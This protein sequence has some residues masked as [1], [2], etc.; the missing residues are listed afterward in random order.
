MAINQVYVGRILSISD[1]ENA[2]FIQHAI[3]VCGEGGKW[4]GIIR[5]GEFVVDD[6]CEVYLQDSLL[7][8]IERYAFLEKNKYRIKMMRMRG[9]PSEVLIMPLSIGEKEIGEDITEELNVE[10]YEKQIPAVLSGLAKGNFPSFIPKTDEPN[11]QIVSKMIEELNGK[12][13]YTTV[14]ADGSSTTCYNKDGEFGVCSR[15]LEMKESGKN[16][17]WQV[18]NKYNVKEIL[19]DKNIAIQFELVG[20]GVQKN[21]MGLKELDGRLFNIYDIDNKKY[22]N[23]CDVRKFSEDYN[24]PMVEI[25]SWDEIFIYESDEQLRK[26]AE[27]KYPNESQREGIVIRPMEETH[28]IIKKHPVR[29]SFKIINLL[30][31]GD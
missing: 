25:I 17:F 8:Q 20:P 22:L 26:M 11:F 27:G 4:S 23:S 16:A 14:K 3:V 12:K 31:K 13:C 24:F 6:L 21:P 10:K 29:L 19:G 15:N 18:A 9:V 28:V 30:Y 7:P 1:I 2:D 5:K